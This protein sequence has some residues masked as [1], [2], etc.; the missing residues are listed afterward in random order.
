VLDILSNRRTGRLGSL[1]FCSFQL[2][3]RDEVTSACGEPL[4]QAFTGNHCTYPQKDGQ[5]E[6]ISEVYNPTELPTSVLTGLA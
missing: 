6:F 5:A 3:H 1:D 2:D 4:Y